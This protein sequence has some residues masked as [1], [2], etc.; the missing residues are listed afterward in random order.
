MIPAMRGSFLILSSVSTHISLFLNKKIYLHQEQ[1]ADQPFQPP[2]SSNL[3]YEKIHVV[4]LLERH[5]YHNDTLVGIS[6]IF[7]TA[8]KWK[9]NLVNTCLVSY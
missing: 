2:V 1:M 3:L 4:L 6:Q 9:F 8:E 5:I 7:L